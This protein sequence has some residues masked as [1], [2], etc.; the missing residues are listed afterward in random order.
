MTKP[1]F[2]WIPPWKALAHTS[3]EASNLVTLSFLF[4]SQAFVVDFLGTLTLPYPAPSRGYSGRLL[5]LRVRIFHGSLSLRLPKASQTVT[6]LHLHPQLKPQPLLLLVLALLILARNVWV[7]DLL[8]GLV[9]V[10]VPRF[11]ACFRRD[12]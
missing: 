11:M 3:L 6:L 1:R 7:C 5:L 10:I 9:T 8:V 12:G 4:L 2:L